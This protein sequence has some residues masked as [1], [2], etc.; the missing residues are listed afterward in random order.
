MTGANI[1]EGGIK[2]VGKLDA[3]LLFLRRLTRL[4]S[5]EASAPVCDPHVQRSRWLQQSGAQCYL[6]VTTCQPQSTGNLSEGFLKQRLIAPT[7]LSP[8]RFRWRPVS[9]LH[10]QQHV[11][12]NLIQRSE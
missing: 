11:Y 1:S 9:R 2:S 4:P 8:A 5:G 3:S 10:A 6:L 12:V 7:D